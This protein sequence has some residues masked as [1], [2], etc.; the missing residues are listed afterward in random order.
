MFRTTRVLWV[1]NNALAKVCFQFGERDK[2]L[3]GVIIAKEEIADSADHFM[4]GELSFV[5]EVDV[6]RDR[7]IKEAAFL[8]LLETASA[9]KMVNNERYQNYCVGAAILIASKYYGGDTL[10]ERLQE[11]YQ[12]NIERRERD[13]ALWERVENNL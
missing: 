1:V 13:K 9:W 6:Y 2:S 4:A 12:S 10:A 3:P 11:I 5:Q 7:P 8:I